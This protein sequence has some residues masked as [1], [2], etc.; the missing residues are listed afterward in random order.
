MTLDFNKLSE[1]LLNKNM[2]I[3]VMEGDKANMVKIIHAQ[4]RELEA[5]KMQIHLL[6]EKLEELY[7]ASLE[8]DKSKIISFDPK[9]FQ[10]GTRRVTNK[11]K[12]RAESI[13]NDSGTQ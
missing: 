5:H 13:G 10:R 2:R 7:R 11:R 6:K 1:E 9:K 12:M 8:D 4:D 3:D